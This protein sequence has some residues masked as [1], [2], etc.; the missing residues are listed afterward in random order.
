MTDLKF[1]DAYLCNKNVR[2]FLDMI[3]HSEGT[4]G[5]DGYK[6]MFGGVIFGSM[7]DHPHVFFAY[8]NKA[9]KTIKTSAA[10]A[11]QITWTTWSA[12]KKKLGLPDFSEKSQ[13][14]A[15]IELLRE[16]KALPDIVAGKFENALDDACKTWASL[17][18]NKD[19]Q[20]QH[21]VAWEKKWYET[22]GGTILTI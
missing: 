7:E 3:R 18:H 9:G 12:L 16:A 20:P 22:A 1:Y 19:H 13:D 6:T 15:A 4:S 8:T 21:S 11:Y 10:G 2:A 17:P 14:I 5:P